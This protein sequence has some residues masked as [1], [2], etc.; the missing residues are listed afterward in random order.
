MRP[1]I[2]LSC[3]FAGLCA[4]G[5]GIVFYANAS[6]YAE[7][8]TVRHD[9]GR[10]GTTA[11]APPNG[12]LSMF[13]FS[14][15]STPVTQ[16]VS[17]VMV[18]GNIFVV[19]SDRLAAY[20]FPGPSGLGSV[21][22]EPLWEFNPNAAMPFSVSF[23]RFGGLAGGRLI[24]CTL[25]LLDQTEIMRLEAR[26]IATGAVIWANEFPLAGFGELVVDSSSAYL[27]W[28]ESGDLYFVAR[29]GSFNGAEF[30][31]KEVPPEEVGGNEMVLGGGRLYRSARNVEEIFIADNKETGQELWRYT[32]VNDI[33]KTM[34]L[35]V[36]HDMVATDDTLYIA[37]GPRVFALDGAT[38]ALKWATEV[39]PLATCFSEE[40]FMAV[41]GTHVALINVCGVDAVVLNAADGT[42]RWRTT[43]TDFSSLP[44]VS[45]AGGILTIASGVLG[46]DITSYDVATGA[47]I[48]QLDLGP[49]T[50]PGSFAIDG[51]YLFVSGFLPT[52]TV[53]IFE[54]QPSDLELVAVDSPDCTGMVGGE[55]TYTYQIRNNGPGPA[56]N[57]TF[58]VQTSGG[59]LQVVTGA[60]N[61]MG[62]KTLTCSFGDLS[63]SGIIDVQMTY[64]PDVDGLNFV[65]AGVQTDT[66]E[67]DFANNTVTDRVNVSPFPPGGIDLA[68][69]S[70]EVTQGIQDLMNTMPL[71]AEK[72]TF[73]RAYVTTGGGD[74]PGVTASLYGTR[75]GQPLAD[76][77]I[78]LPAR[79]G[80]LDGSGP[81]RAL[82][83]D[84]LNFYLPPDWRTGDVA[85]TVI[86][87]EDG[88]V[89]ETN[90]GNNSLTVNVTFYPL[91]PICL[92]VFR[93]RTADSAGDDLLPNHF[94]IY[95]PELDR[96][97]ERALSLLPTAEMWLFPKQGIVEEWQVI[98]YG[99]Y[100]L[101]TSN[102]GNDDT[103]KILRSLKWRAITSFD[104][105]RCNDA[106]ARTIYSGVVSPLTD[107][108]GGLG[109]VAN[110]DKDRQ[111]SVLHTTDTGIGEFNNPRGGRTLAH[112][113]G[114]CYNRKHINCGTP[115]NLPLNPDT[116]YPYDPCTLAPI[117]ATGY[118]GVDFRDLD[119][120]D[121]IQPRARAAN[122]NL[123]DLMSYASDRF[124]SD[125]TWDQ[126]AQDLCRQ[127][128][129]CTWP[130]IRPELPRP[131]VEE[132]LRILAAVDVVIVTG[133]IDGPT[134]TIDNIFEMDSLIIPRAK[135]IAMWNE[136]EQKS[137]FILQPYTVDLVAP[138]DTVLGSVTVEPIA[139]SDAG[140]T[141]LT[142]EA[143]L[144]GA[145]GAN[146]VQVRDAGMLVAERTVS[147][148]PPMIAITAPTSGAQIGDTLTIEW[149]ASDSD[150]DEL[151]FLVQFSND[152]G[153]TWETIATFV[154]EQQYVIGTELLPGG[155]NT[156]VVRVVANDGFLTTMDESA[157]FTIP[158]HSP[159]V[160]LAEPVNNKTFIK[161]DLIRLRGSAYD[162]EDTVLSDAELVWTIAGMGEVGTGV[163]V[164]LPELNAGTY[165][166]T[167]TG[168]DSD[169]NSGM[170]QIQ[171]V[172]EL[173]P[174]PI[175]NEVQ[176]W[177]EYR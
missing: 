103:S 127:L 113:L 43:F 110:L 52:G 92:K 154:E 63:A 65:N 58:D 90:T 23:M 80:V 148:T 57:V 134:V 15:D 17:Q 174:N 141:E 138:D 31:R 42:E 10:S 106:D 159:I 97:K 128:D 86:V 114:H 76:S 87:N 30:W 149:T 130:L 109:G 22:L 74:V 135:R 94:L 119:N 59:D 41:D 151:D 170:S 158:S 102:G 67:A 116:S 156:C 139:Y 34:G 16:F 28:L 72:P 157:A 133:T 160:Q 24:T 115:G 25:P 132:D 60:G 71:V 145:P 8:A 129:N 5:V 153:A 32:D 155:Q 9:A 3:R 78:S 105:T 176:A 118:W 89:P 85:L 98:E 172:V 39:A 66:R 147:A 40:T 13:A 88:S 150:M 7:W 152:T 36:R 33:G 47:L 107:K 27:A 100:E 143:I 175:R 49:V 137:T 81:N 68:V 45:I 93:V 120:V 163:E 161:G 2:K 126:I 82:I 54:Q 117:N 51:G 95:D 164:F 53:Q 29:Y 61:C 14:N 146:R 1:V 77:P 167:L 44:L 79:C 38:G 123:S 171:F 96:I 144:P 62:N 84:T 136:Q 162:P 169:S 168:T 18:S 111:F 125:Y 35:S 83:D 21:S 166:L 69:I 37:Q 19:E 12:P 173:A 55:L 91:P 104:P 50:V 75:G 70:I 121:V 131:P 4:V 46:N 165:T 124:P 48:D 11:Q 142:F 122:S 56:P 73:V 20:Q 140:I 112:E 6:V 64:T 99:P 177:D 101:D 108:L 26:N